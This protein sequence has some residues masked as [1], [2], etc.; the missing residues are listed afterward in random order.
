ME[1]SLK[2][3]VCLAVAG[4]VLG[5][6]DADESFAQPIVAA[7]NAVRMHV[8]VPP[9]SWSAKLAEVAQ[10]WA[11]TLIRSGTFQHRTPY[12]YGENLFEITGA[13]ATPA[14]VIDAWASEARNYRYEN[15]SCSAT[16]GHYTQI[17]WRDTKEVGC[18]MAKNETRQVWV[19]EYDPPGN[20]EG[21]RP[22]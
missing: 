1:Q 9:V 14:E 8:G 18:G 4:T 20:I 11:D 10:Q 13:A 17:V 2:L 6:A 22:Y 12:V 15:N 5:V 3:I 16:C 21:E 19:C 7:H